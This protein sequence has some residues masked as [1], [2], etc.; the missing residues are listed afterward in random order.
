[1]SYEIRI[2]NREL[3]NNSQFIPD[4]VQHLALIPDYKPFSVDDDDMIIEF[5][6]PTGAFV[7]VGDVKFRISFG[8]DPQLNGFVV[9]RIMDSEHSDPVIQAFG[10]WTLPA[11]QPDGALHQWLLE[12]IGHVD[13]PILNVNA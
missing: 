12:N 10:D 8:H 7:E 3:A 6:T 9:K 13:N 11:R 4:N 1:M 2:V 5:N